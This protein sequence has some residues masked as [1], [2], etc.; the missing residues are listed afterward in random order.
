MHLLFCL[1]SCPSF[2]TVPFT[3]QVSDTVVEPYNATLSV[4][5]LVENTDIQVHDLPSL[6]NY[7][8]KALTG[9]ALTNFII[10]RI[11]KSDNA[12]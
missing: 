1:V 5:Q 6:C 11:D 3:L 9:A 10:Q 12:E 2:H 4:H 8:E 7:S